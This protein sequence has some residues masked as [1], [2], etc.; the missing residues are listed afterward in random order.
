[1]RW[2]SYTT[3]A[4]NVD[5]NNDWHPCHIEVEEA[6]GCVILVA[7]G[8]SGSGSA[9]SSF[10]DQALVVLVHDMGLNWGLVSDALNSTLLF[11]VNAFI[12]SLKICKER[13]KF[14]MD[15]SAGDGAD[16]AEDSGSSQPYQSTT[17]N[18]K[19]RTPIFNLE[20]L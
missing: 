19:A 10:E 9:W 11:K 1:M 17:R 2:R 12:G 16:S 7:A 3:L 15:R 13:H 8:Q 4:G 18:S 14:L 6:A 20:D 5:G